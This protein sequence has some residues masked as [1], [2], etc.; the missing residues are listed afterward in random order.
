MPPS[1]NKSKL[2]YFFILCVIA[3]LIAGTILVLTYHG[4]FYLPKKSALQNQEIFSD[5]FSK[6][7]S[8]NSQEII[9]FSNQSEK[10]NLKKEQ[11]STVEKFDP[12][13]HTN[14][15]IGFADLRTNDHIVITNLD[16][17][18]RIILMPPVSL[19]GIISQLSKEKISIVFQGKTQEFLIDNRTI[20]IDPNKQQIDFENFQ[21]GNMVFIYSDYFQLLD[22]D[23]PPT[24]ASI[25]V[26]V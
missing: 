9:A 24:A 25:Q 7:I 17:K 5:S 16:S 18:Y 19:N 2:I 4:V 1:K 15:I 6:I 12:Y 20:F 13:S 22:S 26:M 23:T 3:S 21:I 11:I 10:I 14:I 8:I